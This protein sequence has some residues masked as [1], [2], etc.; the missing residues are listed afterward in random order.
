MTEHSACAKLQRLSRHPIF[1]QVVSGV[2]AGTLAGFLV[3]WTL[4]Y[5]DRQS[6]DS[7]SDRQESLVWRTQIVDSDSIPGVI[8]DSLDLAGLQAAD[9]SL[10][11]ASAH[12]AD[13]TGA[14]FS[15]SDLSGGDF[16]SATLT[17]AN[18]STSTAR[19]TSFENAD[20][21]NAVL[22]RANLVEASFDG[23]DLRGA[24]LWRADLSFADLSAATIDP[25]SLDGVCW[26]EQTSFPDSIDPGEPMCVGELGQPRDPSL[27]FSTNATV[28]PGF[29]EGE[30]PSTRDSLEA[31]P[32]DVVTLVVQ[33]DNTGTNTLNDLNVLVPEAPFLDV[34]SASPILYNN[35]NPGGVSAPNANQSGT[36][37]QNVGDYDADS[38]GTLLIDYQVRDD[39]TACGQF[40]VRLVAYVFH[41]IGTVNDS[42]N[43][44]VDDGRT[45]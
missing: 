14:N 39:E 38:T 4:F 10:P 17:G 44:D 43:V 25:D 6:S 29:W 22:T 26:N 35:Q 11:N 36:I 34:V 37:H 3:G 32:G 28:R 19:G 12:S 20:M 42:I 13:L 5:L 41:E 23:T 9:K 30:I 18:L 27:N 16:T 8:W 45:C 21:S 15:N 40:R 2:F 31:E 24:V 33:I 7:E 1:Q